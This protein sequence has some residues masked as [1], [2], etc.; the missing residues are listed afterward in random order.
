MSIF[1]KLR[2]AVAPFR[3]GAAQLAPARPG[4]PVDDRWRI[5]LNDVRLA[6]LGIVLDQERQGRNGGRS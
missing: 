2:G 1:K 4:A 6:S 5:T 3:S